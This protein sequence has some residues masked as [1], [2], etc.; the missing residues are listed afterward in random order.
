A[1]E[2]DESERGHRRSPSKLGR[3]AF[4]AMSAGLAGGA[5]ISGV[6]GAR[7]RLFDEDVVAAAS[8]QGLPTAATQPAAVV[9]AARSAQASAAGTL[10]VPPLATPRVVGGTSVF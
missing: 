1:R 8:A 2:T 5:A 6:L 10:R 9:A 4:L 3:R 7:S